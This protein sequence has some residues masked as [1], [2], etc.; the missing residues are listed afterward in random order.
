[1]S[2]RGACCSV[3][4]E[5]KPPASEWVTGENRQKKM[6]GPL[7][8]EHARRGSRRRDPPTCAL[9]TCPNRVRVEVCTNGPVGGRR[10]VW[11]QEEGCQLG[12]T[13][14]TS[15]RLEVTTR[16]RRELFAAT[17]GRSFHFFTI[18]EMAANFYK[19][20]WPP[21]L[22]R[23]KRWFRTTRPD[24]RGELLRSLARPSQSL[25]T[26]HPCEGA[27]FVSGRTG[28]ANPSRAFP[29]CGGRGNG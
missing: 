9:G 15:A 28:S 6:M 24:G 17:R 8:H 20:F 7:G 22:Q 23:R 16:L 14:C 27:D 4:I 19:Q 29:R 21:P 3:V 12:A 10:A 5:L 1:M 13:A 2:I 18:A 25:R 26:C 11:Q